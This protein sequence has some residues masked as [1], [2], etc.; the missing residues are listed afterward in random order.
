MNLG[1][2]IYRLRTD[3]NLSQG[4]LADALDVSRQSVSKWENNSAVPELDKLIKMAEVF[5][6]SLDTLVGNTAEK[7]Q[8]A[9]APESST[10]KLLADPPISSGI[11]PG[12]IL[13]F[14]ATALCMLI[15]LQST[16]LSGVLYAAPLFICSA[17]CFILKRRKALWCCWVFLF[18]AVTWCFHGT[19]LGLIAFWQI[20]NPMIQTTIQLY[21]SLIT[22]AINIFVAAMGFWTYRSYL[23]TA[24][25]F[26]A[27]RKTHILLGWLL[28]FIPYILQ[29]YF[30]L[31]DIRIQKMLSGVQLNGR[32]YLKISYGMT[33]LHLAAILTMLI[34][35]VA[36]FRHLQMCASSD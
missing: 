31:F 21:N 5:G 9:A 32:P 19:G 27:T 14:I 1:E 2:N 34:F 22:L 33:W 36:R 8:K 25:R 11:I 12:F 24:V 6:I 4:D 17:I 20:F 3:K 26:V 23:A 13:L 35:T 30:S 16:L 15:A 28:T 7:T 18:S 10:P 29:G